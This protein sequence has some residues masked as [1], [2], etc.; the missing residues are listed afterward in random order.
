VVRQ[1]QASKA[2]TLTGNVFYFS[3]LCRYLEQHPTALPAVRA[4]G[5]GGSPVPESLLQRLRAC[6]T[7]AAV[8]VIYGSSEAE[9]IAVRQ[10]TA[11]TDPRGG[12]CVGPVQAGLSCQLRPLGQVQLPDGSRY[13]VGEVC[14]QGPHV[15]AEPGTWLPTGD[16]GYFDVQGLLW[17]TSRLGNEALHQGVQHYQVEHVLYGVP[18]V[19]RVAARATATGFDVYFEGPATETA[20]RATLSEHFPAGLCNRILRRPHLPVDGRHLSK[21]LYEQLR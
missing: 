19:S 4:V 13:E 12:Y 8:Y 6:F 15:A 21:I 14:V 17:L 5:V 20:I 9:P 2:E 10:A 11:A 16:F 7:G 1:L 18:G 3:A